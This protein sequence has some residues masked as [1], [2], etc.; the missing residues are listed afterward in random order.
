MARLRLAMLTGGGEDL[1]P[2][3][4][5]TK[6]YV[7]DV[8]T[9]SEHYSEGMGTLRNR[10]LAKA[11][12]GLDPGDYILMLDPDEI[13]DETFPDI[14]LTAPV[15]DV[16]YFGG[17]ED[18]EKPTLV[19]VD[20][21]ATWMRSVHEYLD[22]PAPAVHLDGYRVEQPF[23]SSKPER[24]QW[25]IAQLLTETDDPRSVY[26]LAQEYKCV[27]LKGEAL[28]WYMKRSTMGGY[29]EER[30]HALFM[31]GRM[32]EHVDLRYAAVLYEQVIKQR[33]SRPEGYYRLARL[34]DY[35]GQHQAAW[36]TTHDGASQPP[37]TDELFVNRWMQER[38]AEMATHEPG[39][40]FDGQNEVDPSDAWAVAMKG[41]ELGEGTIGDEQAKWLGDFVRGRGPLL[42]GET[43]FGLARSAWAMLEANPEVRVVSFDVGEHPVV[44]QVWKR[45]SDKFGDRVFLYLGDSKITVPQYKWDYDLV[46]IDGGHDYDTAWSDLA[47]LREPGR[48]VI[49]DDLVDQPWAQGCVAAWNEAV[50][51]GLVIEKE[52]HGDGHHHTWAL[53]VYA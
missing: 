24:R 12:E 1:A 42:I 31:A 35:F 14:E 44:G 10:L 15:Y 5:R 46:I 23:S 19:R 22:T 43:G 51:S 29:E 7:T 53:G 6:G 49:F 40:I 28:R 16:T 48:E 2:I 52:R 26:Y 21:E 47:N 3:L 50:E 18:W 4:E 39:H 11:R 38:L 17:G 30:W 8:V 20:A 33:P 32:A 45:L 41:F 9:H 37:S 25:K 13:P 36:I 27:D 34:Q